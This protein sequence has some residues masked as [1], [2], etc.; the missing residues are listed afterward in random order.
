MQKH[1]S[2]GS[3]DDIEAVIDGLP[4]AE[5]AYLWNILKYWERRN[6]KGNK[7][8]DLNKANDYAHRLAYGRWRDEGEPCQR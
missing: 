5:G 4:A 8:G 6:D 3:A 2:P 1:Y 7:E